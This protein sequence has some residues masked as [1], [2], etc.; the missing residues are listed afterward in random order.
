MPVP[1]CR[2]QHLFAPEIL[3]KVI[4]SGVKRVKGKKEEGRR[5]KREGRRME[6]G[7]R[8][9]EEGKL[10]LSRLASSSY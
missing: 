9:K 3:S 7:R 1:V 5:K 10:A 8:K 4:T 6:E 2:E